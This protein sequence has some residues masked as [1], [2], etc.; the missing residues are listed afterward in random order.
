[1]QRLAEDSANERLTL[2]SQ[3]DR[4]DN[5]SIEDLRLSSSAIVPF[6]TDY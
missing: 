2:E 6:S 3:W 4:C 1:M 5:A